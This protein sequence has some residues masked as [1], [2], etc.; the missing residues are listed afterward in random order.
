MSYILIGFVL[1]I[2]L[3]LIAAKIDAVR[4][5]RKREAILAEHEAVLAELKHPDRSVRLSA[6][7]KVV[8]PEFYSTEDV[9]AFID[10]GISVDF[11][12]K[13]VFRFNSATCS[14]SIR[15]GIPVNSATPE[16][17]IAALGNAGHDK[18]PKRSH[19]WPGRG[20]PCGSYQRCSG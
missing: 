2:A 7:R 3:F 18:T 16:K 4:A 14:D 17:R 13:C 10:A 6:I 11:I 9:R 15:P 12:Q 19:T 8:P 20:Y 1:F 5:R